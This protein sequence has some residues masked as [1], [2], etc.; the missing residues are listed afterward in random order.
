[1]EAYEWIEG[2][3][4]QKLSP[5]ARNVAQVLEAMGCGGV[6]NRPI[7][8]DRVDWTNES[9]IEINW[10]GTLASWDSPA[11]TALWAWGAALKLRVEVEPSSPRHIKLIFWQRKEREGSMCSR[12]PT[13]RK[14]IEFVGAPIDE[15]EPVVENETLDT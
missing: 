15:Y 13:A 14:Q 2:N 3:T 4:K 5:L 10:G 12:L 9:W 7:S 8:F 6:Y 11:L 1:M